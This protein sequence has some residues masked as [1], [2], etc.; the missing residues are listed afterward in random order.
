MKKTLKIAAL[1]AVAALI[2]AACGDGYETTASGLKYKFISQNKDGVQVSNGDLIIGKAVI[3]FNDSIIDSVKGE[4]TPLFLAD[5]TIGGNY[6]SRNLNQG[7]VMLHQGDEAEF[8][9][10]A[11]SLQA[12]GMQLPATYKAGEKQT[13]KYRITVSE[14]MNEAGEQ[15]KIEKYLA[16]NALNIKPTEDGIY[17]ISV[18]HGKGPKVEEGKT[19][20]VNYTGRFL[21]GQIFDSSDTTQ[22]PGAHEPIEYVVGQQPMI[23]GWEKAMADMEQGGK[24]RV[25]IPSKL[26][27]GTSG[28]MIPYST[29]L[30]DFEVLS[31]KDTKAEKK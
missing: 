26:A 23:P 9:F 10:D 2:F 11:D 21:D 3:I 13:M 30:F 8:V 5:T 24:A 12:L 16:D 14:L 29:L 17:I 31:V 22:A 6:F 1:A 28:M 27:Y 19:I 25:M 15:K 18:E 7:L 20:K 4:P